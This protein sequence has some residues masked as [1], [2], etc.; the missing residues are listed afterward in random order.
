MIEHMFVNNH[1][2]FYEIIVESIILFI[3]SINIHGFFIRG[4]VITY[5]IMCIF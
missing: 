1:D 3:I 2:F 5:V 4:S